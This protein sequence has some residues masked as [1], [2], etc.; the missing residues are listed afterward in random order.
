MLV[1]SI[2]SLLVCAALAAS[3]G[4]LGSSV[5]QASV[6]G[7]GKVYS[8]ASLHYSFS[9]PA[10]WTLNAQVASKSAGA[11]EATISSTMLQLTAPD[12]M[13]TFQVLVKA[14][15]TNAATIKATVTE[16]L[17]EDSTLI[18]TIK[19]GTSTI[20][21][22]TYLSAAATDKVG[23]TM[24]AFGYIDAVSHGNFTYYAGGAYILKQKNSRQE[25]ASLQG[26]MNSFT[27]S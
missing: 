12:K 19:Y 8:N 7:A 14:S 21:G 3:M 11:L 5:T 23:P 16:L 13:G 9:Y 20:K 4:A 26:I 17:K 6:A 2:R 18:G 27:L 22:V 1:S 15:A 25:S 10:G 24:T